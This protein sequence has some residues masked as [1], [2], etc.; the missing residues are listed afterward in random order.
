MVIKN[1]NS[2][3]SFPSVPSSGPPAGGDAVDERKLLAKIGWRLLPLL[4]ISY[5]IAYIDRINV[6]FAKLQL[7]SALHVD[8]AVFGRV[9]GVGAGLF[10]LGYFAFEVPSNL[11]LQR[12]G[13]RIWI[14]RIMVVWGMVSAGMVFMHS[15]AA[16]YAMRFVLGVA[17]AGFFPGVILYV[18]YWFPARER[19]RTVALFAAGSM[20]AGVIGSTLSGMI[21]GLEGVAGLH[22]WQ[23]LFLLEGMP[24]VIFG[25]VV[26][27]VLPDLP[28]EARWL[29]E[30]EKAWLK[31]RLEL[32]ALTV[33]ATSGHNIRDAL[34]SPRVWFLC[35]LYFL[36]NISGYG[37][38]FWAPTIVS[39]FSGQSD[40]IVGFINA[41]PY[42]V[43]V[44]AM[45][46]TAR[47]SDRTGE[48][49]RHIAFAA[50]VSGLGFA[51]S[52][53]FS[54]PILTLGALIL[55]LAGL[56]S[57]LGPFWAYC[58]SRLDGAAAA[59]GIALI[60]SVG[61]LG[62]FAGPVI[63]GVINDNTGNS[64]FGLTALS[65]GVITLGLL[66]F[67]LTPGQCAT[68]PSLARNP[69]P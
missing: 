2:G 41:I 4:I 46:L 49:P 57:M 54:K 30:P 8:P 28:S 44:G 47:H 35:L 68:V 10:F 3:P 25:V 26:F 61:N 45:M 64:A 9:Y 1:I 29:T 19:A 59:V 58:T 11:I 20:V 17:E 27:L 51:L 15:T 23:W 37:Y 67:T 16:F 34:L 53:I 36:L 60:N 50:L 56:K 6:G 31:A 32:E 65:G 43:S 12:V 38:E 18:T 48:R 14:A 55:A 40:S 62:G 39:G 66:A 24:A 21:L 5:M 52:G 42:L 69:A 7:Q 13:A 63:V 22:G 33:R